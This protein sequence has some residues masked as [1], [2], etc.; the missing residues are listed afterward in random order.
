MFSFTGGI[1]DTDESFYEP[2]YLNKM[3][4]DPQNIEDLCNKS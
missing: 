4:W 1:I 2:E 3:M